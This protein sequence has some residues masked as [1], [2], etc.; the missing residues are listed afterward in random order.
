MSSCLLSIAMEAHRGRYE[1]VSC[2]GN[3]HYDA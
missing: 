3:A 2:M 1:H